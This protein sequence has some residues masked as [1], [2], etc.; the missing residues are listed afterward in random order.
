MPYL[1]IIF[2]TQLYLQPA[3]SRIN[4]IEWTRAN[5]VGGS[6]QRRGRS[7]GRG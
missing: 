3:Y 1:T 5:Q 7:S 2:Q 4:L 6:S